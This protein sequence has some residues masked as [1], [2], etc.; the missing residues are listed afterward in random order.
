MTDA[1]KENVDLLLI[2]PTVTRWN[3]TYDA[4]GRLIAIFDSRE[5]PNELN[6]ACKR[7]GLPLVSSSEI[8]ATFILNISRLKVRIAYN[9]YATAA[10]IFLLS[11]A[12]I[13]T[14]CW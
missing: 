10:L 5:N 9:F 3:S 1:I 14:A 2:L 7:L 4:L 13:I 12:N 8:F 11:R 6:R